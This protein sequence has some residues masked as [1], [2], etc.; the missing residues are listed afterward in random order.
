MSIF[1]W[2][3]LPWADIIRLCLRGRKTQY[4]WNVDSGTGFVCVDTVLPKIE[5]YRT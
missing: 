3:P 1:L 5:V 2:T 4:T